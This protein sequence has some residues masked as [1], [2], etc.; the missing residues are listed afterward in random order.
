MDFIERLF[1]LSPDGGDG[2]LELLWLAAIVLAA[3]AFV[4]RRP[5]LARFRPPAD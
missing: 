3:G 2:L 5:I 4:C 1:S